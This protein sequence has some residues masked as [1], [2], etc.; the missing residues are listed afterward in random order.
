MEISVNEIDLSL[1]SY[2]FAIVT[3]STIYLDNYKKKRKRKRKRA[4]N[5]KEKLK[6]E[7]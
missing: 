3:V 6:I 5:R 1:I 4:K 7:F 2:G